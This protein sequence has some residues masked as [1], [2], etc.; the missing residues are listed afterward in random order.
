MI[1]FFGF[2]IICGFAAPFLSGGQI[3]SILFFWVGFLLLLWPNKYFSETAAWLKW[4]RR[5]LVLNILGTIVLSLF[6]YVITHTSLSSSYFAFI[7]LKGASFVV[8][9]VSRISDL[10]FPYAQM[11]RPDGSTQ[12]TVSF[13][14]STV[15]S[16]CDVV[17]YMFI[18][19]ALW[20]IITK[21]RS[22]T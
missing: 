11:T 13:V 7:I 17:L 21:K 5:G 2:I 18:G 4:T 22:K 6:G 19:F 20:K 8:S 12:F 10:L 1:V 16:F 14:R 9:P 3:P 15:T